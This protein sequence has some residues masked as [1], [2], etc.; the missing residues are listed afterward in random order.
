MQVFNLFFYVFVFLCFLIY[1][2][3]HDGKELISVKDAEH[4]KGTIALC[5]QDKAVY[6]DNVKV[7][8]TNIPNVNMSPV[9]SIG[10]ITSTWGNIK[11]KF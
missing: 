11:D 4:K 1:E 3:A 8:G 6:F 2:R 5:V 7:T 10:K 9:E